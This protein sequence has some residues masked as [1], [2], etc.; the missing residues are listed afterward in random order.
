MYIDKRI[1]PAVLLAV[2][3]LY[4]GILVAQSADTRIK[5]ITSAIPLIDRMFN[6]FGEKHQVPGFI[7]GLVVDG[8]LIHTR[9]TG[10]SNI[11]KKIPVT[12]QSAFRIASM[13]K[14]FTAM[15]IL[16]LRDEGRLQLD[17]KVE[18][19]IPELTGQ[20]YLTTDAAPVTIR[21]LLTHAAGFPEDNPW[22]DR[23]LAIP[24]T[25]MLAM[26]KKGIRFSNVPGIAYEYSNMGFAMLGYI[27]KKV[28]GI[29][30]QQYI[31]NQILLPLG[32]QHT[33]WD[34]T[35]VPEKILTLGYR[36]VNGQWVKQ[37]M[38]G[39]GAYGAMGGLITTMED[40]SKYVQLHMDAWP[41]RNDTDNGPVKRS[42]LREMQQ[43]WNINQLN[44]ANR[45]PGGAPCATVSAYGYGL[46][47]I[48]DCKNN[49][50]VGH[51]GGLPGFG[52][53]WRILPAYGVGII[54]FGNRTYTPAALMN[55]QLLD[56]LLKVTR[57]TPLP[58]PVSP[59]L[60]QRKQELLQLLPRWKNAEV[61]GIFAENFFLDYFTDSLRQ[62]ATTLF[63]RAGKIIKVHDLIPQNQLRGSF[64]LEGEHSNISISF[65]LSPENPPLIQ[66]YNIN[67][68]K[69]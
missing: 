60:K 3:S 40:F 47:W 68:L 41:P 52:S 69:K 59:I 38:L 10:Y 56:T 22:A 11:E 44:A 5:S 54:S 37:P 6:E 57:L 26:I 15:A 13:T 33:Y 17:E 27:I 14:S 7:Y 16:K 42:S 19:Y 32:M 31:T 24:D 18:K 63:K 61:S 51:S 67:E 35:R 48:K 46:R 30:Y 66:E 43:A 50:V 36:Q 9:A 28:S 65:T 45:Y 53:E 25:A 62:Q 39:D 12:T 4:T 58:L 23:Q 21:Q 2:A 64:L 49:V 20:T 34:Y 55:T 8:R 1:I 29:P